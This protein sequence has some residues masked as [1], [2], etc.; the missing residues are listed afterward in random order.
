MQQCGSQTGTLER[1][2]GRRLALMLADDYDTTC[3]IYSDSAPTTGNVPCCRTLV[4]IGLLTNVPHHLDCIPQ[5]LFGT[6]SHGDCMAPQ[7]EEWERLIFYLR[8]CLL[9]TTPE[10]GNLGNNHEIRVQCLSLAEKNDF[11]SRLWPSTTDRY[12][13]ASLA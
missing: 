8:G 6:P 1:A 3:S 9:E 5:Q 13:T 11:S 2:E 7:V 12:A 4:E 10:A